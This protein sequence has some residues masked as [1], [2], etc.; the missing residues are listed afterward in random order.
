LEGL[1]GCDES[2]GEVGVSCE[3]SSGNCTSEV[4]LES[5]FD[6]VHLHV[7]VVVVGKVAFFLDCIDEHSD[8]GGLDDLSVV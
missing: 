1:V 6:D 5:G 2:V 4:G 7:Y 3:R 8:A